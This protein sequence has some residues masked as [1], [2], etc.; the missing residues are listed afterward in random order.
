MFKRNSSQHTFENNFK[1]HWLPLSSNNN[2][3]NNNNN[4]QNLYS[5][6]YNL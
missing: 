6:L 5:A 4:I 2:N 3:N 1:L